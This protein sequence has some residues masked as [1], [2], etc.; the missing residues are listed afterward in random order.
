MSIEGIVGVCNVVDAAFLISYSLLC[1]DASLRE[2]WR[3]KSLR[4]LWHSFWR[5]HSTRSHEGRHK[6]RKRNRKRG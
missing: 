1:R 6:H 2:E 3:L 5:V 4:Y